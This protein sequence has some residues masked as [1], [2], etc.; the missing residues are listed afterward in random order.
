MKVSELRSKNVSDLKGELLSLCKEQ[1]SLRMQKGLG[2]PSKTHLIKQ[3]KRSI[4]QIK[5]ILA[6]K[7]VTI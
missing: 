4:A 6:E 2:Q 3:A 5:T 7:G 1:F